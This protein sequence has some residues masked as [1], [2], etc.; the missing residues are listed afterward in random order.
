MITW[1]VQLFCWDLISAL[2]SFLYQ[3]IHVSYRGFLVMGQNQKVWAFLL[4]CTQY[5]HGNKLIA[6]NNEWKMNKKTIIALT[7]AAYCSHHPPPSLYIHPPLVCMLCVC[8]DINIIIAYTKASSRSEEYRGFSTQHFF[9]A[10]YHNPLVVDLISL[11]LWLCGLQEG[12][13]QEGVLPS[14]PT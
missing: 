5:Q 9:T 10:T 1:L 14:N 8:S 2:F 6:E 13:N 3:D 7:K 11:P 12:F 4:G